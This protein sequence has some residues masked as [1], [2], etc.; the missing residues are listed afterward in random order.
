VN[1]CTPVDACQ[2]YEKLECTEKWHLPATCQHCIGN[3]QHY[4]EKIQCTENDQSTF[5]KLCEDPCFCKL[6]KIQSRHQQLDDTSKR[7]L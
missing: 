1:K 5:D 4:F 7:K 2:L 3:N 6:Q